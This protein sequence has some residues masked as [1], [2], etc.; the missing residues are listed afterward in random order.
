M[1][2]EVEEEGPGLQITACPPLFRRL[3]V[4]HLLAPVFGALLSVFPL[5]SAPVFHNHPRD[6]KPHV[7]LSRYDIAIP[8][9]AESGSEV[10]RVEAGD[11]VGKNSLLIYFIHSGSKDNF[12]IEPKTGV[13]RVVP[14]AVLDIE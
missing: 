9:N 6:L 8:D 11:P 4:G 12:K 1:A 7:L 3:F 13:I 10:S 5:D 14:D 2:G